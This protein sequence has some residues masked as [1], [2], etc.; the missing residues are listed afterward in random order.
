VIEANRIGVPRKTLLHMVYNI[1][2]DA[3]VGALP[4]LGD[5]FDATWKANVKNV[6]L[7]DA[8]LNSLKIK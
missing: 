8:Y 3:L 2:V 6:A 7:L 1:G 5:I 4:I